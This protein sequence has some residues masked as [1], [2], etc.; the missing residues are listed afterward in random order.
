[1][2]L[3]LLRTARRYRQPIYIEAIAGRHPRRTRRKDQSEVGIEPTRVGA[4]TGGGEGDGTGAAHGLERRAGAIAPI[5]DG[6]RLNIPVGRHRNAEAAATTGADQN[7]AGAQVAAG[8]GLGDAQPVTPP[9]P[10]TA[11]IRPPAVGIAATT[12]VVA[13]A[14]ARD[15]HH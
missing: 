7:Q 14:A 1:M 5:D 4:W 15:D 8:V 11:S 6:C 2:S 3:C 13:T 9:N 10:C 12:A